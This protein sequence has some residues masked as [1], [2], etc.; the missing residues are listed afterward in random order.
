MG[1]AVGLLA[2]EIGRERPIP[3]PPPRS[4]RARLGRPPATAARLFG[5]TAA[6]F[7]AQPDL[8][9]SSR[10]SYQ[11]TLGPKRLRL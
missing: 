11:Q 6:A 9:A 7:L 2:L 8:A 1:D 4:R 3:C 5:V 10:H